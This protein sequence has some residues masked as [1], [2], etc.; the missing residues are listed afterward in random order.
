MSSQQRLR[1][2]DPE[3]GLVPL[4]SEEHALLSEYNTKEF[5]LVFLTDLFEKWDTNKE[6]DSG[7][8]APGE[9]IKC[10]MRNTDV[11][12][13]N[14]AHTLQNNI[15]QYETTHNDPY[16]RATCYVMQYSCSK[17]IV[18]EMSFFMAKTSKKTNPQADSEGHNG[19]MCLR[20][21]QALFMASIGALRHADTL[22]PAFYWRIYLKYVDIWAPY[23][24]S[25]EKRYKIGVETSRL[26]Q[27]SIFKDT[28]R[29]E[30]LS[31][32]EMKTERR[33]AS[34]VR[35]LFHSS[36]ARFQQMIQIGEPSQRAMGPTMGVM[37]SCVDY[38]TLLADG[39]NVF[40]TELRDGHDQD[41]IDQYDG[42]SCHITSI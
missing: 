42:Q 22:E 31:E 5:S 26:L 2:F 41:I 11:I 12:A 29:V 10:L 14:V 4:L 9:I 24:L 7:D 39:S 28:A 20:Y 34:A 25:F 33:R 21:F 40:L 18:E 16:M 1:A 38:L 30:N 35:K 23:L 3:H 15:E 13:Q 27:E 8:F 37:K 6:K 32:D 36:A 17:E 19:E